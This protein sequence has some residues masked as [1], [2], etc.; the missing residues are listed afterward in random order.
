[1]PID[2]DDNTDLSENQDDSESV[3]QNQE[4]NPKPHR[5]Y[6][7]ADRA[8]IYK[9]KDGYMSSTSPASRKTFVQFEIL[10]KLFNYWKG[11][12]INYGKKKVL[13][14]TNVSFKMFSNIL[15]YVFPGIYTVGQKYM[16]C[17]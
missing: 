2:H 12:G 13:M 3:N 14:K 10:P 5:V 17:H 16:A 7:E 4:S 11:K 1:M 9:F 6:N 8:F 15:I